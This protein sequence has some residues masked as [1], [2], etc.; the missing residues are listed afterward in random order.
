MKKEYQF[1]STDKS[2]Q[3]VDFLKGKFFKKKS[4]NFENPLLI[5]M[6]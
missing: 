6:L 3:V 2:P 5:F 4:I 1:Y